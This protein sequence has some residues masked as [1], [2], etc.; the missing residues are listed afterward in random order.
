MEEVLEEEGA[1]H[2]LEEC[3]TCQAGR[4]GHRR[5]HEGSPRCGVFPCEEGVSGKRWLLG[6]IP[7]KSSAHLSSMLVGRR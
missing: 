4:I 7:A 1:E 2:A 3:D 6:G 5:G